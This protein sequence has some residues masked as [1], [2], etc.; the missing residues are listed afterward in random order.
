MPAS[1]Q[2]S[3]T[4]PAAPQFKGLPRPWDAYPV[5]GPQGLYTAFAWGV[6][7]DT[8]PELKELD[9]ATYSVLQ[10]AIER[11]IE[12]ICVAAQI[13]PTWDG[14]YADIIRQVEIHKG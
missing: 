9:D 14:L 11:A 2:K 6:L 10:K 12:T 7:D 4:L 8:M 5:P 1:K 13:S 3:P